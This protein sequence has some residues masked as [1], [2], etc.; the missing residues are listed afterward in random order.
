MMA[1]LPPLSVSDFPAYLG[2]VYGAPSDGMVRRPFPWQ[3][4]LLSR[5]VETGKW[6]RLLDLPTGTGKTTAIDIALFHLALEASK[7]PSERTALTRIVLVVDR[8]TIVDQAHTQAMQIRRRLLEADTPVLA[9]VRDR[10]QSFSS[11]AAPLTVAHLRGGVLRDEAWVRTPV[12]PVIAVSTVDQVGSRLLFRGYGITEGMQPLHAGLLGMDTLFLLDEV[13]LSKPFR[14]TLEGIVALSARTSDGVGRGVQV[15]LLSATPGTSD[16]SIE[17]THSLTEEDRQDQT[18][19]I[20]LDA[21]KP[22]ACIPI[23][24]KGDENNR[25]ERVVDAIVGRVKE[26]RQN[27]PVAIGVIVNRVLTARSVFRGLANELGKDGMFLLTGRMRPL[28]RAGLESDVF[29][30]VRAGRKRSEENI[31]VVATQCIEAGADFDFD[32]LITECA[33][34]DSIKQRFGRLN[35]LGNWSGATGWIFARSD[36]VGN[37]DPV[38]GAALTETWQYLQSVPELNFRIDRWEEP[39]EIHRFLSKR[40][41]APVLLPTHLDLWV[42]TRPKPRPDPEPALWLHGPEPGLPEVRIIWRAVIST[43]SLLS[44]PP[45]SSEAMQVPLHAVR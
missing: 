39:P 18:L 25:L 6:P 21:D 19:R 42:Q 41:S 14:E 35:R 2:G 27:G 24:V 36:S 44:C 3:T 9:A 7:P 22:T 43:P 8:R 37:D 29:S 20:R 4:R 32:H 33:S 11:E 26:L 28:D 15:T 23:A 45:T 17:E 16:I 34:L 5:V 10:L 12:Q 30:Y 38:Y 13:H 1:D 40:A 31:I